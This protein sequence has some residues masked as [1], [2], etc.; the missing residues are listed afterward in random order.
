MAGYLER[1]CGDGEYYYGSSVDG[2]A[3]L[4]IPSNSFRTGA[5]AWLPFMIIHA[6]Y[7]GVLCSN[8]TETTTSEEHV[9]LQQLLSNAV[10]S[11]LDKLSSLYPRDAFS[12][13]FFQR[14]RIFGDIFINCP[15]YYS[16]RAVAN[17]GLPPYKT[18][19]DAGT[20]LHGATAQFLFPLIGSA[21]FPQTPEKV[22]RS[23]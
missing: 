16:V 9:D 5:F 2:S 14:Q 15:T 17:F 11:F 12:S 10:D 22:V 13:S 8:K 18:V 1:L 7:E 23:S 21:P 20:K 6:G 3:I 4:G 19:F